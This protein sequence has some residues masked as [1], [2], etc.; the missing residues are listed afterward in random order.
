[1]TW[2]SAR[3]AGSVPAEAARRNDRLKF[4]EIKF[5][6]RAQRFGGRAVLKILRQAIQPG[7]ELNLLFDE[8]GDMVC[9]SPRPAAMIGPRSG[10]ML[11]PAV[12]ALAWTAGANYRRVRRTRRAIARLAFGVSHGCFTD[13]FAWHVSYSKSLRHDTLKLA[14]TTQL[15]FL[16]RQLS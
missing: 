12:S 14:K 3:G 7:H 16:K 5:A 13:W 1:M 10:P 6:D 4:A 8:A 15:R 9:P 2:V 11:H